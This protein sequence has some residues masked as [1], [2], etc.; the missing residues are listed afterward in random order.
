M[1]DTR[2]VIPLRTFVPSTV[3]LLLKDFTESPY[4]LNSSLLNRSL[5]NSFMLILSKRSFS[6]DLLSEKYLLDLL[7]LFF[8]TLLDSLLSRS[9]PSVFSLY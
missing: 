5:G 7:L 3:I 6:Y 1:D 9:L 8:G 2:L 4:T